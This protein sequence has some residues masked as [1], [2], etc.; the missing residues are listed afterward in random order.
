MLTDSLVGA[1]A[2]LPQS[3]QP[4][5]QAVNNLS[6]HLQHFQAIKSARPDS[7][8]C[9]Q[10]F[11]DGLLGMLQGDP[12]CTPPSPE[13]PLCRAAGCQVQLCLALH[14]CCAAVWG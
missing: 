13:Q 12:V 6:K 5:A 7:D 11:A 9:L 3:V 4:P 1:R 10:A 14:G 8:T 2:T